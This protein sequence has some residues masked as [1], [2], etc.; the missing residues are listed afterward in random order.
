MKNTKIIIIT[1]LIILIQEPAYTTMGPSAFFPKEAYDNSD[2]IFIGYLK[3]VYLLSN[4]NKKSNEYLE[5]LFKIINEKKTLLAP[6]DWDFGNIKY[7]EESDPVGLLVFRVKKIIKN[8]NSNILSNYKMKEI[9]EG[10]IIYVVYFHLHLTLFNNPLRYI[11]D[12]LI[13]ALFINKDLKTDKLFKLFKFIDETDIAKRVDNDE[14]M[15]ELK[16]KHI[17]FKSKYFFLADDLLSFFPRTEDM[18]KAFQLYKKSKGIKD[19]KE[20]IKFWYAVWKKYNHVDY[21]YYLNNMVYE[22]LLQLGANPY[23]QNVEEII[24]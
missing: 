16:V 1:L 24:K 15:E 6:Y 13:C 9:K 18:E 23:H 7:D 12:D 10:D 17:S 14:Y 22:I 19:K 2:I 8:L 11:K 5:K 4:K 20:K 21:Y 3:E